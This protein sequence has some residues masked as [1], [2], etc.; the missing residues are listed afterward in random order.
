MRQYVCTY[1]QACIHTHIHTGNATDKHAYMSVAN[2][3]Q[4]MHMCIHTHTGNATDEPTQTRLISRL[5]MRQN[6]AKDA[7]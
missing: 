2:M 5:S 7:K 1:I 4:Y 6:K 3:W